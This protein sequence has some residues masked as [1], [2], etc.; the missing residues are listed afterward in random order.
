LEA[1]SR[2][3][4][5]EVKVEGGRIRNVECGIVNEGLEG[6]GEGAWRF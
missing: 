1:A 4:E 3:V 2:E 5:V 6:I